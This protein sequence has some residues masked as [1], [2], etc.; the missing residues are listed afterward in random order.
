MPRDAFP[1]SGDPAQIDGDLE[2]VAKDLLTPETD[3]PD[4][5]AVE[6]ELDE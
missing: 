5:D 3:L 4:S 2:D 1:G 6:P